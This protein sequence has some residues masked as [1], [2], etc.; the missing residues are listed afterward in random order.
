MRHR[1]L[2]VKLGREASHRDALMASLVCNLIE[3]KRITT[4][5]PK[6][7]AARRL[8]ERMVTLGKKGDLS[9]RRRAISILHRPERVGVLFSAVAP[10]F[11][12]RKGGYTRILKLGRR[13][14]DG[15]EMAL[16]EWVNYVPEPPKPKKTEGGTGKAE[17]KKTEGTSTKT[18]EAAKA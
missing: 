10:A 12:D 5:L 18:K 15:A 4:T 17:P 3:R 6:A 9:A 13:G 2:T 7:K 8:A 1:K 16:L 14:G 11:K